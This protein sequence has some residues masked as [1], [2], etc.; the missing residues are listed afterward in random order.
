MRR[1]Q[2]QVSIHIQDKVRELAIEAWPSTKLP[3]DTIKESKKG[4]RGADCLQIANTR[5]HQNC[6]TIYY[7]SRRTK[8]FQAN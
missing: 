2:D 4:E 1:K 6:V 8:N 7:E 3:L 5:S